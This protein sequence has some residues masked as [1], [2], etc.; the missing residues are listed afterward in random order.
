VEHISAQLEEG[1]KLGL[2]E[3]DEVG[4]ITDQLHTVMAYC[5]SGEYKA[6]LRAQDMLEGTAWM[7]QSTIEKRV[8]DVRARESFITAGDH[9]LA[10]STW[11]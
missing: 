1:G 6:A 8:H 2:L 5:N 11:A 10:V 3:V 4:S 7:L 9:I